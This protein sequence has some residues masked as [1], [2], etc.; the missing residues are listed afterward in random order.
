MS[1]E[2][3]L[4]CP[5]GGL[6]SNVHAPFRQ[7]PPGTPHSVLTCVTDGDGG[8]AP[9]ATVGI[10]F[11]GSTTMY[12]T[13]MARISTA[14]FR[15]WTNGNHDDYDV[16]IGHVIAAICAE[17]EGCV[18]AVDGEPRYSLNFM[19]SLELQGE[20]LFA[21]LYMGLNWRLLHEYED[22]R[23]DLP[24]YSPLPP[25]ERSEL[26]AARQTMQCYAALFVQTLPEPHCHSWTT[27]S[28]KVDGLLLEAVRRREVYAEIPDHVNPAHVDPGT[29]RTESELGVESVGSRIGTRCVYACSLSV[30]QASLTSSI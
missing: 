14:L 28:T 24:S 5:P 3:P 6:V 23:F 18:E 8:R 20:D 22:S 12:A 4:V 13:L 19:G 9:C 21:V 17:G 27:F 2:S 16:W 1:C 10:H 30:V 29:Y 11:Y 15:C 26:Y 25:P 7:M